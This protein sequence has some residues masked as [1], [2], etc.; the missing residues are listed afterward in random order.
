MEDLT[1]LL[2]VAFRFELAFWPLSQ[3]GIHWWL[4]LIQVIFGKLGS[5]QSSN[6]CCWRTLFLP[7]LFDYRTISKLGTKVVLCLTA[8]PFKGL[9]RFEGIPC[10]NSPRIFTFC[11]WQV[12]FVL[13]G[14]TVGV[15][16][17]FLHIG[18][19]I[20]LC[21]IWELTTQWVCMTRQ[22][23]PWNMYLHNRSASD[24]PYRYHW[25]W[26]DSLARLVLGLFKMHSV[27]CCLL[28][29]FH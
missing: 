16:C 15:C 23:R 28:K 20:V 7:A 26:K 27:K 9:F 24:K 14:R 2:K 18:W 19:F 6:Y 13:L 12:F 25:C 17:E 5:V 8:L 11:Q 3:K 29:V 4:P 1:A 10:C 22:H 21:L